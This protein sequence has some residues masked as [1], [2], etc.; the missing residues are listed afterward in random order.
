MII[1]CALFSFGEVYAAPYDVNYSFFTIGIGLFMALFGTARF[2]V[3]EIK[4]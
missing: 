1:G 2:I 3:M 4:Q